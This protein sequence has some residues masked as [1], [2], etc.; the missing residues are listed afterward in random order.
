MRISGEMVLNPLSR[1]DSHEEL[2]DDRPEPEAD[3]ILARVACARAVTAG[4]S[5]PAIALGEAVEE[6]GP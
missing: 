1:S 6:P 3:S 2:G 4:D 5:I